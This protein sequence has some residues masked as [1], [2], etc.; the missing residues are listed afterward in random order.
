MPQ[1]VNSI[2]ALGPHVFGVHGREQRGLEKG[3]GD[4]DGMAR[5]AA[6]GVRCLSVR[7]GTDVTVWPHVAQ[8]EAVVET[9]GLP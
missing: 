2:G 7:S 3:V 4:G 5:L 6:M 8:V 1:R 9:G